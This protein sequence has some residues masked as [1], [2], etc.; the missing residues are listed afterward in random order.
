MDAHSRPC[1][2]F[3]S[4]P[5][6]RATTAIAVLA[7]AFLC[8][9]NAFAQDYPPYGPNVPTAH[10]DHAHRAH[11][12]PPRPKLKC[13]VLSASCDDVR[14]AQS[15]WNTELLG[16]DTLD[17]RSTYQPLVVHQGN[18]Y[19]AYMAHHAGCAINRLNGQNEVNG[20]S[21]LDV[22]DPQHPV[23]LHHVVGF[24]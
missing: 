1:Q 21:I 24:P 12:I 13:P 9:T 14:T 20:T 19:I 18:R 22:T 3:R 23:Y 15:E 2:A 10:F 11:L 8:K 4:L 17:G 7:L 6:R 5:I 16:S